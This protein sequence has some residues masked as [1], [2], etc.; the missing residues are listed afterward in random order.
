MVM[1]TAASLAGGPGW[2]WWAFFLACYAAGGWQPAL[3]GLRALRG[4]VLDVDLLMV[5]AA[6]GAAAIGQVLDGGLLHPDIGGELADR[7]RPAA[8]PGQDQ[9]AAGRGQRL[10]RLRDRRRGGSVEL[11]RR[12]QPVR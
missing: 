7:A 4:R 1:I 2:L 5:A 9:Q 11:R 6:I 8:E 12:Y 10:H 3:A